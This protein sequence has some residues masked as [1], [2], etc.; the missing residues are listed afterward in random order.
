MKLSDIQV[1]VIKIMHEAR[2]KC[3]FLLKSRCP[4]LSFEILHVQII[5]TT[6]YSRAHAFFV[7]IKKNAGR[8]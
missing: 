6:I 3:V 4:V 8:G 1:L 2:I 7:K 5:H